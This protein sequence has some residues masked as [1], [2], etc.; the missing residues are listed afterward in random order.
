MF[1]GLSVFVLVVVVVVV[2]YLLRA[3][4]MQHTVVEKPDNCCRQ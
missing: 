4:R 1:E 3:R 2:F